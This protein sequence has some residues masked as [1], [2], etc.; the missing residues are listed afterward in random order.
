MRL[1]KVIVS[2]V[3]AAAGAIVFAG[4]AAATT[5]GT[6]YLEVCKTASGSGVTGSFQFTVSGKS[7]TYSVGVNRCSLPIQVAAGSVTITELAKQGFRVSG[8]SVSGGGS[9]TSSDNDAG[10]AVVNVQEGPLAKQAIVTFT[11]ETVTTGF[12]EVCKAASEGVSG[13]FQ[14][15]VSGVN[16]PVTVPAGQCS[17]A[18]EL[19]AGQVTVTEQQQQG[20]GLAS[21]ATQ[22]A[23]RLV[24]CD[25]STQTAV[26][27][28]V[29]GSLGNQTILTFT[30]GV[31]EATQTGTIKVCKAASGEG[32]T[33][34]FQFTVGSTEVEAD[35][36]GCSLPV[37]VT[38]GEPITVTE[39]GPSGY[40]VTA[41]SCA[42]G[43]SCG[44]A[45]LQN[46][47]IDATAAANEVTEVTF[48]NQAE[49]E[50]EGPCT[51]TKGYYRNHAGRV[52]ELVGSGLDVG[53][54]TLPAA[55]VQA[56]LNATPGQPGGVSF[57]SNLTLNLSQQLLSAL[58]N[59]QANSLS[60]SDLP[61]DVQDAIAQAIAGLS[62]SVNG[63]S[64]TL[65][66]SQQGSYTMSQLVSILS[67]FNE[68]QYAGFSHCED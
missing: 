37:T 8:V 14:F 4:Q 40:T 35:V 22:P 67:Q 42:G 63:N 59:V 11:N 23:E 61:T 64:I 5:N 17:Q 62:V 3:L 27:T 25:T 57:D 18:I 46:K 15:S 20:Y 60:L 56:I 13:S 44:T 10:Q 49:V 6:G 34:T 65:S 68:G 24:S 7:G 29:A 33:G 51:L 21:C 53:S 58:L 66:F 38:A 26:A 54:T 36:N 50:A 39:T 48:T 12:L 30:N 47:T 55:Q 31:V 52:A 43:G 9:L 41:I 1:K 28:I 19:P 2:L 16:D 32:V 45:D